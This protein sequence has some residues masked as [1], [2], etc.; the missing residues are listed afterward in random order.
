[1]TLFDDRAGVPSMSAHLDA[2][3]I[4]EQ[5]AQRTDATLEIEGTQLAVHTA[6][7]AA[8][9]P[10]FADLFATAEQSLANSQ[11]PNAKVIIPMPG[12]TLP[13][14]QAA[15]VFIYQ[16]FGSGGH[17]ACELLSQD[18]AT[19]TSV[20]EFAHKFDM[21][22]ISKGVDSYMAAKANFVVVRKQQGIQAPNPMFGSVAEAARWAILAES[23]GLRA[24]LAHAELYMINNSEHLFSEGENL[25]NACLL[26][27]VHVLSKW[28]ESYQR[29]P[30]GG[31]PNCSAE[32]LLM[33]QEDPGS[34]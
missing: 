8:A 33:L 24:L 15:L 25:S 2:A 27:I 1:M 12:H 19:A 6:I 7:L 23:C 30:R 4:P 18:F 32:D 28:K 29:A 17:E 3:L 11:T 16:R 22:G 9:S 31:Y 34:L 21:T 5:A 14:V 13:D 26:R 10:V 20:L